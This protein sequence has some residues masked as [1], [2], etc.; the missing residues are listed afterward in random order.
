[1]RCEAESA[2]TLQLFADGFGDAVSK[3]RLNGLI[4]K[5]NDLDGFLSR[6]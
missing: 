1:V 5:R 3:S 4:G 2:V 6:A